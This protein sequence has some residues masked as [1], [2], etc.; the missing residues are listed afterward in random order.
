MAE[1]KNYCVRLLVPVVVRVYAEHDKAVDMAC[2]IMS[3]KDE[4]TLKKGEDF[5][6]AWI[7]EGEGWRYDGGEYEA[8]SNYLFRS[9]AQEDT[10]EI[11]NPE[12]R[13]NGD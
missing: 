2:S 5:E 1:K 7:T 10:A 4:V 3:K 8:E 9:Q 12:D 11:I 13:A 6:A